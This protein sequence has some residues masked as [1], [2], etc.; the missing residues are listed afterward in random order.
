MAK[1][2]KRARSRSGGP[3]GSMR[4]KRTRSSGFMRRRRIV[5]RRLSTRRIRGV[6]PGTIIN[7]GRARVLVVKKAVPDTYAPYTAALTANSPADFWFY[8][9][10]PTGVSAG[11]SPGFMNYRYEYIGGTYVQAGSLSS[12]GAM[13]DM[14]AYRAL[15]QFIKI[16]WIRIT[17]TLKTRET[18]D[19]ALFPTIW[20]RYM[21]DKNPSN[22]FVN[23]NMPAQW[24]E[25]RGFKKFV[26]NADEPTSSSISYKIYPRMIMDGYQTNTGTS[27]TYIKSRWC[28]IG[29]P[30]PHFGFIEGFEAPL[31]SGQEISTDI[32]YCVAFK[33]TR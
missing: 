8:S 4:R 6:G 20:M 28:D 10:D 22:L 1:G 23:A 31:A 17:H 32:E 21:Y 30:A 5:R 15:Y 18:T 27:S 26:F 7:P 29:D 19:G 11:I 3:S 33:S 13:P 24:A 12:G 25:Y 14:T 2:L 16:K 9:F